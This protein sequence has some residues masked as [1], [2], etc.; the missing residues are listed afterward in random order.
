MNSFGGLIGNSFAKDALQTEKKEDRGRDDKGRMQ[1]HC[2][3]M[4]V[5]SPWRIETWNQEYNLM[6]GGGGGKCVDRDQMQRPFTVL[7][8][9]IFEMDI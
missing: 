3:M 9:N 8:T 6:S 2:M 5:A 1:T 7:L 4:E